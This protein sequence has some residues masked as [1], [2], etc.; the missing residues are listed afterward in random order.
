VLVHGLVYFGQVFADFMTGDG[1]EFQYFPDHGLGNLAAM[2]SALR[3]CDLVYQIGGR[4]TVGKFLTA[5]RFFGRDRIVMHWVG[6]D[7]LDQQT[8]AAAGKT[9]SWIR[10]HVHHWSDSQW[11]HSEVAALGISSDL[12]PL[13]SPRVPEL[14]APLPCEFCVLVYVPSVQR[15]TLYGLDM[16]LEVAT[17][18]PEVRFELV[19]L[20]DGPFV[21]EMP[22]NLHLHPRLENLQVFYERASVV[23]RP[24]RHDGL[25]WM[26]LEALGYGRHVLWTYDFPG[27]SKITCAT[28]AAAYLRELYN[29][30]QRK[31]LRLNERGCSFIQNGEYSPKNFKKR[32][33]ARLEQIIAR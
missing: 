30:H 1:W 29:L 27:C 20:R 26:V 10:K 2:T 25:S 17:R 28:Q 14:P 15:S 22:S 19:G 3:N 11:I 7:T 8:I 12:V 21:G 32:I 6:S 31:E 5:A 18:L 9:D 13:P 23:W 4:V 33:L 16:I 24:A